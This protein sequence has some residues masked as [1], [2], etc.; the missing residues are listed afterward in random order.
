MLIWLILGIF[1][2]IAAVCLIIVL[3]H[4]S[5]EKINIIISYFVFIFGCF[6]I[7]EYINSKP[8]AIDV[9]KGKTE[10]RITYE[11]NTPVDSAVVFKK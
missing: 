1:L 9:Y 6:I 10:L 8:K 4:T 5:E 11:G 2:I 3:I 7:I